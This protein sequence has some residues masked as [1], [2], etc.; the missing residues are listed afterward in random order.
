E[1]R[2]G[3]RLRPLLQHAQHDA[4]A[5][6]LGEP[7][8]LFEGALR[9]E[10]PRSAGDQADERRPLD[11]RY[12]CR[13]HA[14][15]SC[16]AM[17]PAR[18]SRGS[19]P[20]PSTMVDGGPPGVRPASTSTSIVSPRAR[21]TLSGSSVGGSPVRFAL[22]AVSGTPQAPQSAVVTACAGTRTPTVSSPPVTSA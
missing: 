12:S 5:G 11:R 9:L 3:I 13:R 15:T 8:Q 22:V 7:G 20:A 16:H 19:S 18:I 6:G 17:A 21:T 10:P 4:R 2:R 1:I 14:C